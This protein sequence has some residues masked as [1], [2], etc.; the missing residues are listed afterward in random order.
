MKDRLRLENGRCG[1][2][3]ITDDFADKYHYDFEGDSEILG[4]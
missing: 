4:E 1:S 2:E 3:N